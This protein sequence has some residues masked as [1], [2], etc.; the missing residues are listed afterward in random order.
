M[1]IYIYIYGNVYE[2]ICICIYI[3]GKSS[4]KNQ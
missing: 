3:H 2:S 4:M 1:Y